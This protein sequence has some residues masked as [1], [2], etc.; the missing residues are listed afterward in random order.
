[1]PVLLTIWGAFGRRKA[2]KVKK[3]AEE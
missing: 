1:V 3:A 2:S